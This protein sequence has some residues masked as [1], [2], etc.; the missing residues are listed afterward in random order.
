VKKTPVLTREDALAQRQWLLVDAEGKPLGRLAT[1]VATLLRGK[2]KPTFAP[3]LD[4]GDFVVVINAGKVCLTGKKAE[5]KTY[6]RH[7]GYPG[8]LKEMTAGDFLQKKPEF[9]ITSAVKGM[10]PRNRLGRDL[11]K[12]LKVYPGPEHPHR[13]QKPV[14]CGTP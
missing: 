8:G 6:Q 5:N 7:T 10:L 1:R 11:L 2:H 14:L 13:A 12:K 4:A 3:Y 9:L